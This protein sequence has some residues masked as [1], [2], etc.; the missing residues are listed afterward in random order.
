MLILAS[1]L[2]LVF[3]LGFGALLAQTNLNGEE[4]PTEQPWQSTLTAIMTT[5]TANAELY[6]S[7]TTTPTLA[8]IVTQTPQ[9]L[10]LDP[11]ELTATYIVGQATEQA[12]V[13]LTSTANAIFGIPAE[14]GTLIPTYTPMPTYTVEE[15][16]QQKTVYINKLVAVAGFSHPIFDE[17]AN[18]LL[19]EESLANRYL[20]LDQLEV[21]TQSVSFVDSK[22]VILVVHRVGYYFG[23]VRVIF[24]QVINQ[25][26]I[27]LQ[28]PPSISSDGYMYVS[29]G[30]FADLNGNGLPDIPVYTSFGGNCCLPEVH[31]LETKPNNQIVDISPQ[32]KDVKPVRLIDLNDDGVTEIQAQSGS[33][34]MGTVWI[35]RWFGWDGQAYVDISR[36]H[37]EL[38][39]S[40]I[41]LFAQYTSSRACE[42]GLDWSVIENY[43]ANYYVMGRLSEGWS[44]LQRLL[45]LHC[46]TDDL[47]KAEGVLKDVEEWMNSLPK[48]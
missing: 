39:L 41:N 11:L 14:P 21:D 28:N 47:Q 16:S 37:P 25:E 48:S 46:S 2:V 7:P 9:P 12:A 6:P 27:L 22:Y 20:T 36:Q 40:N 34:G 1:S 38:Y 31:I 13:E 35:I 30:T 8:S 43:L 17:I 32:A 15:L 4:L 18:N 44:E 29:L 19:V 5:R 24:F 3:A 42:N 45:K 10:T 23:F 26:P 33:A